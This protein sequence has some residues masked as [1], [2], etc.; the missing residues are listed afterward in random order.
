MKDKFSKIYK[1][2]NWGQSRLYPQYGGSGMG[3][4]VEY[5]RELIP[6]LEKYILDKKVSSF[7]DIGCG[8][9]EWQRTINW[10]KLNCEYIGIE[11]LPDIVERVNSDLKERKNMTIIQGDCLELSLPNSDLTFVKEVF[12][13]WPIHL[14]NHCLEKLLN[15]SKYCLTYNCDVSTSFFRYQTYQYFITKKLE[16]HDEVVDEITRQLCNIYWDTDVGGFRP[17]KFNAYGDILALFKWKWHFPASLVSIK[18]I[19]KESKINNIMFDS[20]NISRQIEKDTGGIY[21]DADIFRLG[22]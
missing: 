21:N 3:S 14:T 12:Q 16:I 22:D 19:P 10:E 7:L 8:E 20:V 15:N 18:Q 9:C 13:H 4:S 5:V 1:Q 6:V 11:L 2:Q 17:C